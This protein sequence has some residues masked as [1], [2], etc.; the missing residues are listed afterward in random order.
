MQR[1]TSIILL[2]VAGVLAILAVLYWALQPVLK[3]P[4]PQPPSLP[5]KSTQEPRGPAKIPTASAPTV[6]PT[7]EVLKED[8]LQAQIKRKAMVYAS[9]LGTYSS[10]DGF[11][12]L[13]DVLVDVTPE[14]QKTL[15]A[16]RDGLQKDHPMYGPSWGM[17]TKALT[18][19]VVSAPVG[20]KTS[21]RVTVQTTQSVLNAGIVSSTSYQLATMT[22]AKSGDTWKVA[23][24]SWSAFTP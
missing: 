18:A 21:V 19:K 17:T 24:I 14:W 3:K 2:V 9:R 11:A 6:A 1:R 22:L 5:E 7:T 15:T 23:E 16:M 4:A 13:H 8:E 12:S 20:S 10:T